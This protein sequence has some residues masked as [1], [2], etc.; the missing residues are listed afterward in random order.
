MKLLLDTHTAEFEDCLVCP[1]AL[2]ANA[3][4][5]I[6]A[7]VQVDEVKIARRLQADCRPM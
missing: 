7:V 6:C 1:L 3:R 2:S 5:S 4:A